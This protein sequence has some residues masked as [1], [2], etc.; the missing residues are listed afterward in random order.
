MRYVVNR[1]FGGFGLSIAVEEELAKAGWSENRIRDAQ[2]ASSLADRC[3]EDLLAAIEKVGLAESCGGCA[4]LAIIE[5]PH[6]PHELEIS[7]YDGQE[8][9]QMRT[10]KW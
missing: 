5:V 10:E 4:E 9:I 6:E 1:C 8:T 2:Y 3:S 7:E